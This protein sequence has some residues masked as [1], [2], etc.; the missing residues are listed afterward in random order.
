[1]GNRLNAALEKQRSEVEVFVGRGMAGA[2][3][4]MRCKC[5]NCS[6]GFHIGSKGSRRDVVTSSS[7]SAGR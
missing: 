2:P 4:A 3:L 7:S 6:S 1:M 5:K